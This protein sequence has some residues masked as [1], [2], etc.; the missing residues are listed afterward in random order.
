MTASLPAAARVLV[1]DDDPISRRVVR[2]WL[3]QW[4][5]CVIEAEDG[6]AAWSLLSAPNH[7]P[8]ALIDWMMPEMDGPEVCARVREAGLSPDP[9]LILLTSREGRENLIAALESG[10][11]DY[12]VKPAHPAELRAR[13][14]V[15]ERL[16]RLQR[17][18]RA[19][20]AE[21]EQAR[22]EVRALR[23][24]LPICSTCKK[25]R[26][27]AGAYHQLEAYISRRSNVL[28]SHGYCPDCAER[29]MRDFDASDTQ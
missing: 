10:A 6:K 11:D 25:I 27:D 7:P 24:V 26:D 8:M 17:D 3:E 1:A 20:I 12:L 19:R 14:A 2:G 16:T 9:Y 21:L 5:L 29:L 28:F 23:E 4:G 13:I 22:D 15:G 18:L